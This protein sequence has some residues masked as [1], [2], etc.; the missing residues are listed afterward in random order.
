MGSSIPPRRD[1]P[2]LRWEVI[3]LGCQRNKK[4]VDVRSP[5]KSPHA[6]I[7]ASAMLHPEWVKA[8]DG[9]RVPCVWI[10]GYEIDFAGVLIVISNSGD[11]EIALGFRECAASYPGW[12]VPSFVR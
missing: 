8:M 9:G 5:E 11:Y 4:P 2:T 3:D 10:P 7:L 6:G 12:A 1:R